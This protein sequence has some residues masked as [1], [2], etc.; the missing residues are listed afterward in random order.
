M[1]YLQWYASGDAV[2]PHIHSWAVVTC[3]RCD[4]TIRERVEEFRA[5]IAKLIA[6]RDAQAKAAASWMAA[7]TANAAVRAEPADPRATADCRKCDHGKRA[8]DE[9]ICEKAAQ[10]VNPMGY[11]EPCDD[12]KERAPVAGDQTCPECGGTGTYIEREDLTHDCPR[13]GGTGR[14]PALYAPRSFWSVSRDEE[15]FTGDYTTKEEAIAA[16]PDELGLRPG[17]RFWVSVGHLYEVHDLRVDDLFERMIEDAGED[18]GE[19]AEEWSPA[20]DEICEQEI[21]AAV[22]RCLVRQKEVPG[23]W[24]V[25]NPEP[26]TAPRAT[27]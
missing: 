25:N 14:V 10:P 8:G 13:C 12:F 27:P 21:Y 6:E 18:C 3:D 23:F 26:H 5:E 24:T 20:P 2:S 11:C 17:D 15:R 7:A 9:I 4:M 1:P 19:V 16:A 22:M